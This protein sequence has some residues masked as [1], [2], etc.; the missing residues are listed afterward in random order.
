MTTKE[1]REVLEEAYA[2]KDECNVI[3]EDYIS[4]SSGSRD[5]IV[6]QLRDTKDNTKDNVYFNCLK[7]TMEE[8]PTLLYE[9]LEVPEDIE[10]DV[11][12]QALGS[13]LRGLSRSLKKADTDK[14][15]QNNPLVRDKSGYFTKYGVDDPLDDGVTIIQNAYLV[16][17]QNW[18]ERVR[19]TPKSDLAVAKEYIGNMTAKWHYMHPLHLKPGK[20]SGIRIL[21]R[22]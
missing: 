13:F 16:S 22:N 7:E 8:V 12:D 9:A 18:T 3:I 2:R 17:R 15:P 21:E 20:V 10:E 11:W 1:I 5:T 6:I 4:S 14:K 19:S